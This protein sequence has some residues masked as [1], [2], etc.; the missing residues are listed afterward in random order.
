MN[1][2]N[3]R[4]A[5][6]SEL[7]TLLEFEQC[8]VAAER[9]FDKTLKDGNISYYD[10][11]HLIVS[12]DA[13]VLVAEID[14]KLVGSGYAKKIKAEPF[15]KHQFFSHLGFMYVDPAHRGKGLIQAII[16]QLIAWSKSQ[17]INEVRLEVYD[18]NKGAMRAYEKAGLTKNLVEMRIGL[19]D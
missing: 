17:G 7:A 12:N 2:I 18:G 5:L 4:P 19:D 14:G 13:Q 16:E 1:N 15:L 10:I 6:K 9:P 11:G 3:I 8:I